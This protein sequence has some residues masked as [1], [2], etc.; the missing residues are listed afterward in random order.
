ME[1]KQERKEKR[2]EQEGIKRR[3]DEMSCK[4]LGLRKSFTFIESICSKH[5]ISIQW[6]VKKN[7]EALL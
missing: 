3:T 7:F 6:M 5:Y 2:A 4:A 1:I